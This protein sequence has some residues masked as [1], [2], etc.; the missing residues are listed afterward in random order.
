MIVIGIIVYSLLAIIVVFII[1]AF[2]AGL[3]IKLK[4]KLKKDQFLE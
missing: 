4:K 1:C 3:Y 2:I